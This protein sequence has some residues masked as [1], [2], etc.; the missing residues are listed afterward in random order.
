MNRNCAG[1]NP[2][3]IAEKQRRMRSHN[4]III[5]HRFSLLMPKSL[6]KNLGHNEIPEEKSYP[7]EFE[8]RGC[9]R[10]FCQIKHCTMPVKYLVEIFSQ[11]T[12]FE[13]GSDSPTLNPPYP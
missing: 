11:N 13:E 1:E 10:S 5:H 2:G 4:W 6:R 12:I 3:V 7:E 9:N 8:D